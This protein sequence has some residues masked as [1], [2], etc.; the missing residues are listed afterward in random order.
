[1]PA[2]ARWRRRSRRKSR[3]AC[4][5]IGSATN[6]SEA[7][8]CTSS[9]ACAASCKALRP[10]LL[11]DLG[12]ANHIC[13]ATLGLRPARAVHQVLHLIDSVLVCAR[14][15]KLFEYL[16]GFLQS[17]LGLL[18]RARST[19]SPD[20]L[21][22]LVH[23]TTGRPQVVLGNSDSALR[24]CGTRCIKGPRSLRQRTDDLSA[25]ALVGG[26]PRSLPFG[27]QRSYLAFD[28]LDRGARPADRQGRP[29]GPRQATR[30]RS[31][32]GALRL[33]QSA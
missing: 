1:M 29:T 28:D 23:K 27:L 30:R 8:R 4:W 14:C 17:L 13:V 22:G 7:T 25:L 2:P 18:R 20:P 24:D 31:P 15:A 9:R 32:S 19:A 33:S 6:C 3:S 12:P 5:T 26:A 11:R 21:A 10:L 16:L